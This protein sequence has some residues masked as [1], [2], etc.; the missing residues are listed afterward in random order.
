M[1][2][3]THPGESDKPLPTT[4]EPGEASSS[5]HADASGQSVKAGFERAA[6]YVKEKV[7]DYREGGI[8]QVSQD[9]GEYTQRQPM[10]AL[11]IAA[12]LG[13]VVGMLLILGR[14]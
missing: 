14:R 6:A 7:D 3:G 5:P 11:L 10:T 9:I 4:Q 12:G 1:E 8:E 2:T 13:V